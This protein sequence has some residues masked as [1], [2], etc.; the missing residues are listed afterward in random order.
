MTNGKIEKLEKEIEELE[1]QI[2]SNPFGGL[3]D[4]GRMDI[5]YRKLK[6]K[7]KEL[8][9]LQNSQSGAGKP[10]AAAEKTSAKKPS[11]PEV[12]AKRPSTSKTSVKKKTAGKTPAQKRPAAAKKPPKAG[13][14]V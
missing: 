9:S 14:R 12:P 4:R 13:P 5:L 1:R 7:K 8:T 2:G 11:T 10:T 3:F 6:K